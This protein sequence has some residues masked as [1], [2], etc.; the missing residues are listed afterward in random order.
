[1]VNPSFNDV[2]KSTERIEIILSTVIANMKRIEEKLDRL[3]SLSER[4]ADRPS[5]VNTTA[6]ILR[7]KC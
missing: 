2:Y 4:N 1:M 7:I 5:V 3:T 6:G